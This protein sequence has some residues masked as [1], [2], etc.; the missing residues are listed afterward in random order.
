MNIRSFAKI[1]LGLEVIGKREDGYHEVRTLLQTVSLHDTLEFRSVPEDR[2]ILIGDDRA[3]SWGK[4]N[5]I[6]RAAL[7]LKERLGVSKGVEIR[8]T[9]TIPAGKGLGGGS[10]NAAMTLYALNRMW[11]LGLEK[12]VLVDLGKTL[13]ADVPFFFEGG[14]CLGT[15]KG[16]EVAPVNELEP[17]FCLLILPEFSISTASVYGQLQFSLTSHGKDSK[18]IKFL[19]SRVLGSLE[20]ELEETVFRLYPQLSEIKSLF[21]GYGSELS[22]VS[23]TG[24]AVFGLFSERVEAEKVLKRLEQSY[25]SL[26]VE[27]L[28]RERYRKNF[29]SGV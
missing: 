29:G 26:L 8:V 25:P 24:S 5:L 13:G 10:S 4:E 27:L 21:R 18:I 11:S 2:I 22:L 14:L 17:L 23:G 19:D 28:P 20:N 16:D 6:Y 12:E 7:L 3:I 15:G 1:N 9:K